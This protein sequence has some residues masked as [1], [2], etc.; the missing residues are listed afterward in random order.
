MARKRELIYFTSE[1]PFNFIQIQSWTLSAHMRNVAKKHFSTNV[2]K[3]LIFGLLVRTGT[4]N[5]FSYY[6]W[7]LGSALLLVSSQ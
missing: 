7:V 6:D 2:P 3:V 4:M 1:F 5:D